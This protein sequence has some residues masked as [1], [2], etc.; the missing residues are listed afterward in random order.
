MQENIQ[1]EKEIAV[2]QGAVETPSAERGDGHAGTLG[3]PLIGACDE[4]M[5]N[6]STQEFEAV[7]P[8]NDPP[9]AQE[10][11]HHSLE[12]VETAFAELKDGSGLYAQPVSEPLGNGHLAA[13]GNP[14]LHT[15]HI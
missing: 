5:R 15:F 3:S 10:P 11:I 8:S 14:G 2:L 12:I 13:L 4:T 9:V 7:A 6:N 1:V